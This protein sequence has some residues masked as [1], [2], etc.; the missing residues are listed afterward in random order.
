MLKNL[1]FFSAFLAA[2]LAVLAA[3]LVAVVF[4]GLADPDLVPFLALFG[5]T[6]AFFLGARD[7]AAILSR[8]LIPS[9]L[10]FLPPNKN[11]FQNNE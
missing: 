7:R 10:I 3:G 5:L 11:K 9:L 4:F 6:V 1:Y 8:S 2:G